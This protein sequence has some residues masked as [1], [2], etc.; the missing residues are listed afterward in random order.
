MRQKTFVYTFAEKMSLLG[1]LKQTHKN[2][3]S[4]SQSCQI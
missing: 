3:K 2:L 1:N 4:K